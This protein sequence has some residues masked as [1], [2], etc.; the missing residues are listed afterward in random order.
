MSTY[1]VLWV[2]LSSIDAGLIS[3]SVS[4]VALEARRGL[5]VAVKHCMARGNL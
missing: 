1:G 4:R 3:E 5:V 2:A